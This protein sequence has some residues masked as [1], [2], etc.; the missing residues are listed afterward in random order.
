MSDKQ[1]LGDGVYVRTDDA[2]NIILTTENGV[3]ET[4]T[5]YLEPEVWSALQKWAAER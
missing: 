2:G 3:E 1:Y 4:N 5:I